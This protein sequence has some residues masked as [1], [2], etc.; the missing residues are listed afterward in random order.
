[1]HAAVSSLVDAYLSHLAVERRLS[2][3]TVESYGRDL[4]QLSAA[5]A[6]LGRP[7]DA[8]DRRALE[9]VV[10]QMMGA[11]QSPRSVARAVACFRGFYRFLV[12]SGHRPD[13]PAVDVQ[14]PRAWKTLPKF[15][16]VDEVDLLLGSPDTTHPR[17]L[18]DRA[19]IELFYAT[20]LRVS[21]MVSLRQQDL[22]LESGYLTTM[23][24][25]RKQRLVPI[26]D[27]ASS[28]LKRYLEEG[29]PVLL[30]RRASPKLFVNAR[31]GAGITRVGFWKILKGYGKT[32]GLP[33]TL[34]PHVL[35]HS[36]ATHLLERGA[37]L[38][39]IQMMLGHS[40]LSTT[41]IY[42]HILDARLRAVYDK[43]HPR[44]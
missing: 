26:G 8:L 18:R 9:E 15:L 21:E 36:F 19:L 41:Q 7:I 24:K 12:L 40:D 43:F 5:A 10:R 1:M 37:D 11:G 39:A 3:N 28:W 23:G 6:G 34:S 35:R 44:N 31:G 16:S 25:G 22:N 29:R 38:R 14:A 27:E 13:N 4:C 17:G 33:R 20:G 2:P 42:T 32:A 30:K